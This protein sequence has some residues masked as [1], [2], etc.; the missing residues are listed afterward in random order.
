MHPS[1]ILVPPTAQPAA[2]GGPPAELPERDWTVLLVGGHSG[3]GKSIAA[4]ELAR[5]Y[6]VGVAQADAFRLAITRVT[7]AA[8]H[9][10][11]HRM[12]VD[13]HGL[14][15]AEACA[16]WIEVARTVSHALEP[17]VA[18]HLATG[19][20]TV[21]EGD[22][23]LPALA[24]ARH[25]PFGP[26]GVGVRAVFLVDD[27]EARLLETCRRR[28]R[29][30]TA[31]SEAEQRSEARRHWLYGRWVAEQAAALGLPVMSPGAWDT[32]PARIAGA[33]AR[34]RVGG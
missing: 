14:P 9:P 32:L 15:P 23:L 19:A 33:A 28:G 11:L 31:L 29:G 12:S 1:D 30:F 10:A 27:D 7:T 26:A 6:G 21:L 24:V 22:T 20:P 18:L 25:L 3:T 16:T 4:R 17:V 13:A 5:R 34:P 8:Q 2:P